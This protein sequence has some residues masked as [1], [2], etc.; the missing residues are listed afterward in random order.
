M[1]EWA[2]TAMLTCG[3]SSM[4]LGLFRHGQKSIA[5]PESAGNQCLM[6]FLGTRCVNSTASKNFTASQLFIASNYAMQNGMLFTASKLLAASKY[7]MLNG[8]QIT[9]SQQLLANKFAYQ[10]GVKFA[11][12]KQIANAFAKFFAYAGYVQLAVSKNFTAS[13]HASKFAYQGGVKF[14]ASK[15]IAASVF[16][17]FFAYAGRVK[18]VASKIFVASVFANFFAYAG[19]VKQAASKFFAASLFAKF[20]A[21]ARRVKQVASKIF[22]A[23]IF[24]KFFAKLRLVN[25]ALSKILTASQFASK[26]AMQGGVK[27]TASKIL[28]A[29]KPA[30]LQRPASLQLLALQQRP[31][32]QSSSLHTVLLQ[33][34]SSLVGTPETTRTAANTATTDLNAEFWQWLAGLIDGDGCLLVSKQ[35]YTSCEITMGIA[36][37]PCLRY[38]QHKLGGSVKLRSGVKAWRWRLHNTPGMRKLANGINGYVR[39][40]TR[41]LQL[42]NVCIALGIKPI[43]PTPLNA[44]NAWFAGFFDADGTITYSLKGPYAKP[45]LTLSVTNKN[46]C[47]VYPF[48]QCFGGNVYY[49]QSQNGYYM[50]SIQSQPA[51]Q[52]MLDYFAKCPSRSAKAKRLHLVTRYYE[53]QALKA[54][55]PNSPLHKA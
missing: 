44:N 33:Q 3:L 45:Q 24:A 37:E 20:F 48:N 30:N 1:L 43:K 51:M 39:H 31:F 38:L 49:D 27:T 32:L 50:W 42:H 40:S 53:L 13:V 8:M 19:R 18:Q 17:N 12:S 36:D 54:H 10:G 21:Y 47:D 14:A 2:A 35:G 46:F 9:A 22:A 7:A 11:A 28:T 29:S 25:F 55:K 6:A 52:R 23:S 41:L 5:K 16:A 4:A 26:H 15:Q 34:A